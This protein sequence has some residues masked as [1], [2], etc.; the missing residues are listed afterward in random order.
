MDFPTR[1]LYRSAIEQLARGSALSELE[2]A[3]HALQACDEAAVGAADAAQAGA[4]ATPGY[5]L[6]AEGRRAL[7]REIG[8]TRAVA[9][10][11]RPAGN[12]AWAWRLC[13]RHP[14]G[15]A[16]LLAG[17]LAAGRCG[18]P[19]SAPAGWRCL[20]WRRSC[21][22]P[23]WQRRWSIARSPGASARLS[24]PGLELRDGVP[25]SAA[26]A[27]RRADPADQRG[28]SAG[29]D[30]TAGSAPSVRCRRRPG[31]RAADRRASMPTG[32]LMDG[33]AQLLAAAARGHCAA[34]PAPRT[35]TRR[36]SLP[37]AAPPP[38]LQRRREA[39]GWD[40]SASAA[41][42]TSSTGCCAARPTPASCAG[43]AGAPQVPA[44]CALRHHARC[45]HAPAA[46]RR[47]PADR[48]DGASAEPAALRRRAAARGRAA[49][50]SC[51]RA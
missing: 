13:R 34:E 26:H 25:A 39:S 24:L 47:A 1:N 11:D 6:I 17:A 4:P 7:E 37:A 31:F 32:K 42:C 21:R 10:G 49:T 40:G 46:R 33:D 48:Q 51:S 30:R 50:P 27:G 3:G 38:G 36:R 29:A 15:R 12:S 19:R 20:R 44:G 14:A 43:P 18:P 9:S 28:R 5:H 45:R 35:G 8:F 16:V 41:S 2:I 22:R 23:R